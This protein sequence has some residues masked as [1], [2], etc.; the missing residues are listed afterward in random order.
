MIKIIGEYQD[1][2]NIQVHQNIPHDDY[3][4]LLKIAS[5]MIGNSSSGIIESPSFNLPVVNIGTRQDGRERAD[6]VIDEGYE[7]DKIK[8][9]IEMALN[10]ENFK[11]IVKNCINPYGDGQASKRIIDILSEIKIDKILLQ[12]KMWY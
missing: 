8:S 12:K 4:G 5:V 3:L 11:E 9:A 6:N 10:D 1:Y 7:K 2:P